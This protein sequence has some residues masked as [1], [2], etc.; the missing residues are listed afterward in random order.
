[1]QRR[2]NIEIHEIYRPKLYEIHLP[3]HR[4]PQHLSIYKIHC[5]KVEVNMT[6]LWHMMSKSRS[7]D[8]ILCSSIGDFVL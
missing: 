1:M 4:N 2:L 3:K 5:L 7:V 6:D 8:V